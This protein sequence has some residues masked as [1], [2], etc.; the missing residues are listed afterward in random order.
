MA[1]KCL[2]IIILGIMTLGLTP[3]CEDSSESTARKDVNQSIEQADLLIQQS[4]TASGDSYQQIQQLLSQASAS[5]RQSGSRSAQ[6]APDLLLATIHLTNARDKVN[7]LTQHAAQI[8]SHQA[9]ISDLLSAVL[10][11]EKISAAVNNSRP[12]ERVN[13]LKERLENPNTGLEK[14]LDKTEALVNQ[15]ITERTSVQQQY[16]TARDAS[17]AIQRQYNQ[18][19]IQADNAEGAQRFELQ[20][21]A[22]NLQVGYGNNIGC[23]ELEAQA[24]NLENQL[25]AIETKLQ[26]Q[27][28]WQGML[29]DDINSMKDTLDQ[30][31]SVELSQGIT[32]DYDKSVKRKDDLIELISTHLNELQTAEEQY[33]TLRQEAVD[34]LSSARNTFDGVSMVVSGST[35][36]YAD[37]LKLIATKE[38]AQLWQNDASHNQLGQTILV[39]VAKV[40]ELN[41]LASQI[42]QTCEQ[43]LVHAIQEAQALEAE[44]AA[45]E[46]G[47]PA[48]GGYPGDSTGGYPTGG[49]PE[50]TTQVQ[51]P[52]EVMTPPPAIDQGTG[53]IGTDPN[54]GNRGGDMGNRG[55]RRGNRG[56]RGNQTTDPNGIR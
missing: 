33:A 7:K 10:K 47:A 56:N 23:I 12:T 4:Q 42:Q 20:K 39:T 30:L 37:S 52:E 45:A 54:R 13:L 48:A 29:R 53:T 14:E 22:Y 26:Y 38:L 19:L 16:Q 1:Y 21:Q 6:A 46:A 32:N 34:A 25:N 27:L 44:I 18:L 11:E 50:E 55:N 36:D 28:H 24:Q 35:S 8:H 5:A 51:P 9:V 15:M 31:Q 41:S 40:P 43:G 3:G 2:M 49:Y 17:V